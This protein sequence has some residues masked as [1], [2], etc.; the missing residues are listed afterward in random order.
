MSQKFATSNPFANELAQPLKYF[1]ANST[2]HTETSFFVTVRLRWIIKAPVNAPS[3]AGKY[4][5]FLIRIVTD[6]DDVIER[7]AQKLS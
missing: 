6:G 2:K 3:V 1:I 4:W 5:T 7:L